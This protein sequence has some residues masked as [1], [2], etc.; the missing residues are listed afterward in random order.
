MPSSLQPA[1]TP[2]DRSSKERPALTWSPLGRCWSVKSTVGTEVVIAD[3][4]GD[5]IG[6]GIA[7]L[8]ALEGRHVRLVTS[9]HAPGI[10][11]QTHVRDHAIGELSRLNVDITVNARLFGVDDDTAYFQ[12]TMTEEAIVIEPVET[13]VLALGHRSRDSLAGELAELNVDLHVIGD[14]LSPRTAEEAVLEGL[15]VGAAL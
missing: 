6:V 7:Q 3:W 5:W 2:I 10:S 11:M 14:A 9:A 13:L 15:K 1:P 8:L 12:H 4:R